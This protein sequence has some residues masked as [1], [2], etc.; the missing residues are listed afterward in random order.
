MSVDCV[1][2]LWSELGLRIARRGDLAFLNSRHALEYLR[3]DLQCRKSLTEGVEGGVQAAIF[4]PTPYSVAVIIQ[5]G[6]LVIFDSHTHKKGALGSLI[7]FSGRN[8]TAEDL[9]AF[10][11]G[12]MERHFP[13]CCASGSHLCFLELQS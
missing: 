3:G 5:N 11:T 12:F 6:R 13:G 7:C 9:A 10:L 2:L 8:A 1:L 4:V